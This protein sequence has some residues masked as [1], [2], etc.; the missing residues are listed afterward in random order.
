MVR[1]GTL[2][3]ARLGERFALPGRFRILKLPPRLVEVFL[4]CVSGGGGGGGGE[5]AVHHLVFQ[6]HA[7]KQ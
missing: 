1:W 6:N 3:D 4:V 7:D 2:E 5:M